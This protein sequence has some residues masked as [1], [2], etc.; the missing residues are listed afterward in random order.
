MSAIMVQLSDAQVRQL[1]QEGVY[2]QPL[3]VRGGRRYVIA[4]GETQRAL[5]LL[6]AVIANRQQ[7]EYEGI[8]RVSLRSNGDGRDPQRAANLGAVRIEG[9]QVDLDR[10]GF[11]RLCDVIEA[12]F[13]PALGRKVVLH[14]VGGRRSAPVED[15]D[16]HIHLFASPS[17]ER[18][19]TPPETMW[20]HAVASR[21]KS[22]RPSGGGTPIVVPD[23]DWAAGELVGD[24]NLYVHHDVL[25]GTEQDAQ[26]L[27]CILKEVLRLLPGVQAPGADVQQAR[28]GA[29]T[30]RDKARQAYI[31]A[32]TVRLGDT[33]RELEQNLGGLRSSVEQ[34]RTQLVQSQRAVNDA[35][36]RLDGI[37]AGNA[38]ALERFGKEFDTLLGH[39]KVKDVRVEDGVVKVFTTTLNCSDP[40]TNKLHEIG[41]FRIELRTGRTGEVRWFNLT[42]QVSGGRTGMQAPHIPHEGNACLGNTAESFAQLI[43]DY[44]F[45]NAAFLAIEFVESVNVKDAWGEHINRWPLAHEQ[46]QK[47]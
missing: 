17:G 2:L 43:A 45:A 31:K 22:Y 14:P 33:V 30:A 12:M 28:A 8:E 21:A 41:E 11:D 13:A 5:T 26:I 27:E 7:S 32:C 34:L 1:E 35:Q 46:E 37:K 44:E 10:A 38:D 16:I 25:G 39:P 9:P 3:E 15:A 42:R 47:E 36:G 4:E 6:N 40:R 18:R 19:F 29:Q 23:S 20:Q 24:G